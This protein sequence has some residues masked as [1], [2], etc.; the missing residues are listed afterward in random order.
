MR[1]IDVSYY[2]G[3]ID[4]TKVKDSG[5]EAVIVR[6]GNQDS[7]GTGDYRLDRYA[8][9]N[10]KGA[11]DAGL[12][13]GAYLFASLRTEAGAREEAKWLATV[14]EPFKGRLD[15]PIYYDLEGDICQL[16]KKTLT[17]MVRGFCEELEKR[18]W[19]AGLY[20]GK[21]VMR[22]NLYAN[23]IWCTVWIAQYPYSSG[24]TFERAEKLK[25]SYEGDHGA[26][27]FTS[28]GTVPG[29]NG[30]VDLDLFYRDFPAIIRGAGLNGYN[31][32]DVDGDGK[33][34]SADAREAM[35]QALGMAAQT[36]AADVDGDGKVTA[37]DAREIMKRAIE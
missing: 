19:F 10:L 18:G 26:W 22:D 30:A 9:R 36:A 27:Q 32:G 11:I 33:V 4:W 6:V 21:Y 20:T 35:R 23:Q 34:T 15:M 13:V 1:G 8:L 7:A 37:A 14:L 28:L 5:V 31:K 3:Y 17:A 29:I 2:Q 12:H 25:S 24:I 16:P